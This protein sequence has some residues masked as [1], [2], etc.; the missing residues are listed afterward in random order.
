MPFWNLLREMA[1]INL[2]LTGVSLR[3][4]ENNTSIKV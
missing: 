1:K 4:S 3:G 2:K